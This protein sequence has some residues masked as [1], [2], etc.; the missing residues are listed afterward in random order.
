MPMVGRTCSNRS[1]PQRRRNASTSCLSNSN[2]R[3]QPRHNISTISLGAG[4]QLQ[5]HTQH[6][7]SAG[8]YENEQPLVV[9][10]HPRMLV[11]PSSGLSA[12]A[13]TVMMASCQQSNSS[14]PRLQQ[15]LYQQQHTMS[16]FA[17]PSSGSSSSSVSPSV[18]TV[19]GPE[20]PPMQVCMLVPA[21]ARIYSVSSAGI[22]QAPSN[23]FSTVQY[24]NSF[25]Q[26]AGS[27]SSQGSAAEAQHTTL[28]LPALALPGAAVYA[29]AVLGPSSAAPIRDSLSYPGAEAAAGLPSG[30]LAGNSGALLT[31][32]Q[33]SSADLIMTQWAALGLP[34]EDLLSLLTQDAGQDTSLEVQQGEIQQH[35]NKLSLMKQLLHL[36]Q[37]HK[38][39][40]RTL[41]LQQLQQEQALQQ[42]LLQ[43]QTSDKQQCAETQQL[44]QELLQLLQR[45]GGDA[46]PLSVSVSSAP[47]PVAHVST[48]G[49]C[50][51]QHGAF[52]GGS[53]S[54]T[55]PGM[56]VVL[57][58]QQQ[59]HM[60]SDVLQ[61]ADAATLGSMLQQRL[62]LRQQQVPV[63]SAPSNLFAQ[64]PQPVVLHQSGMQAGGMHGAVHLTQP[65]V[66]LPGWGL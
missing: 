26:A 39:Q 10:G 34:Q 24:S 15:V 38:A 59:L 65:G 48:P 22:A 8:T 29:D 12:S 3:P 40:Q 18:G 5:H 14:A 33:L 4:Q 47:P 36:K 19:P 52:T 51:G 56:Y 21:G 28:Q 55:A 43:S 20:G 53:T 66:V 1:K 49:A 23:S 64:Q 31:G 9:P 35:I 54:A 45:R 25:L 30:M 16:P 17:M 63:L 7:E 44:Q 11:V 27:C 50:L 60:G 41:Q 2:S 42:Q 62:L 6:S 37:Q 61:T 46:L 32:P 58:Q 13:T 57:P